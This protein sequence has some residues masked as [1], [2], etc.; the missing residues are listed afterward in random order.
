[1]FVDFVVPSIA[2]SN[3]KNVFYFAGGFAFDEMKWMQILNE[4]PEW[5]LISHYKHDMNMLD[6]VE[7][8]WVFRNEKYMFA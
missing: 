5:K 3:C 1:M 7:I 2:S 6:F 8:P 4:P